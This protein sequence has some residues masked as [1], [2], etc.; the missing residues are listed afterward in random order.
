MTEKQAIERVL[1]ELHR[2]RRKWPRWPTNT[3][4]AAAIVAEE[5]GELV[6][7]ALKHR[8]EKGDIA[9]CDV[10][11]VHTAAMAIRFLTREMEG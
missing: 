11:A 4:Q 9:A 10:E 8:Y 3:V 1:T 2:A 5:A 6:Q 7:T